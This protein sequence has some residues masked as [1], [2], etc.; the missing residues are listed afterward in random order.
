M[1]HIISKIANFILQLQFIQYFTMCSDI[2]ILQLEYLESFI[3]QELI[4]LSCRQVVK[5]Y[6]RALEKV[7]FGCKSG[8]HQPAMAF[9]RAM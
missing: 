7:I 8:H 3:Y 4:Y 6:N 9:V 1:I 2:E 5:F